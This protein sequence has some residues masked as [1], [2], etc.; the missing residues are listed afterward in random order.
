MMCVGKGML[1]TVIVHRYARNNLI[2]WIRVGAFT[3][4]NNLQI[5][6]VTALC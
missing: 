4:L 6:Y 3:G 2:A 5:M 1:V